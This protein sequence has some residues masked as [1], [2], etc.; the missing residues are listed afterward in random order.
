MRA[1]ATLSDGSVV[2]GSIKHVAM[3]VGIDRDMRAE[4]RVWVEDLRSQGVKAAHPDDGW[5]DRKDNKVHFCYPQ[6]SNNP[7][8]GDVVALGR[9]GRHRLV[10][11]TGSE[12]LRIAPWEGPFWWHFEAVR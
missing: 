7:Q 11:L 1:E 3:M 8:V 5:V 12:E 4:E 10:R 9:P 2:S 6:F